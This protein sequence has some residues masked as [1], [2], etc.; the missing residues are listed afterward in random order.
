MALIFIII[1]IKRIKHKSDYGISLGILT[2]NGQG[3][4]IQNQLATNRNSGMGLAD[5]NIY[6]GKKTKT[7]TK[8]L[9]QKKGSKRKKKK[10]K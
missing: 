3:S 5:N 8:K 4:S 10:L 6:K 2:Q 7:K 1:L 9:K